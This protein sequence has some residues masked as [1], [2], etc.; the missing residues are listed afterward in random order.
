MP[1]TC[2]LTNHAIIAGFGVPGRAAAEW[3][4][5]HNVPYCVVELNPQTVQRCG[6]S[7]TPI[8]AGSVA[9]EKTLVSA[10][11]EKAAQFIIAVPN[12]HAV[13][14]AVVIA[15]RLNPN[16]NIIARCAF[17]SIGL[18]AMRRGADKV[19]VAEQIVANEIVRTL[20]RTNNPPVPHEA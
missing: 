18:E 16:V 11:M 7:G 15:R 20:D 13:L 9:D 8:I 5:E 19:I 1:D 10:G 17:T 12:D 2:Q 3:L 6:K 4:A 14:E